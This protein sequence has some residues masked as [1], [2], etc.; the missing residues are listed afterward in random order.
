[1]WVWVNRFDT[2]AIGYSLETVPGFGQESTILATFCASPVPRSSRI[3]IFFSDISSSNRL[4]WVSEFGSQI[5][6]LLCKR[7]AKIFCLGSAF[8][9]FGK[10]RFNL[11]GVKKLKI[12]VKLKEIFPPLLRVMLLKMTTRKLIL[13]Y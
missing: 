8:V 10:C 4:T 5:S 3:A 11:A 12:G 13:T 9:D 7:T 1:M 2:L 6:I